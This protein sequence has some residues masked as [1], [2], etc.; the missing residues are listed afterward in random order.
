MLPKRRGKGWADIALTSGGVTQFSAVPAMVGGGIGWWPSGWIFNGNLHG[1]K[2][3][4]D[5]AR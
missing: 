3:P 1:R 4:D 2:V 5:E